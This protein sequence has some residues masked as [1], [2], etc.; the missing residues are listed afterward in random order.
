MK[1]GVAHEFVVAWSHRSTESSDCTNPQA[2]YQSKIACAIL[3][4]VYLLEKNGKVGV[5]G[6]KSECGKGI[7]FVIQLIGLWDQQ[8]PNNQKWLLYH[9]T[10]THTLDHYTRDKMMI[11]YPTNEKRNVISSTAAV[12]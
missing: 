4:T 3:F 7:G 9:Y 2:L 8:G 6:T 11:T 12:L 1:K 10:Y 5:S